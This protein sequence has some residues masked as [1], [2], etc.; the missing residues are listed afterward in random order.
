[1][2]MCLLSVSV[3]PHWLSQDPSQLQEELKSRWVSQ[4]TLWL[5]QRDLSSSCSW[6][7]SCDNQWGETDTDNKHMYTHHMYIIR[8]KFSFVCVSCKRW[9]IQ[10]PVFLQLLLFT[11]DSDGKHGHP[12]TLQQARAT[13][14][15]REHYN[16]P[17]QQETTENNTTTNQSNKKQQRTTL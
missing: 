8:W 16:K 14:S 5:T 13:R 12:S 17:E 2:Y 3:S 15:N 6:E 7:G 10:Q 9:Y 11:M 4:S 1:V